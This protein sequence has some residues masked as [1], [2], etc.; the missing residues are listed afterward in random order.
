MSKKVL[1]VL[2]L[3][4]L[5][6]VALLGCIRMPSNG[7]PALP[8]LS[9]ELP[10]PPSEELPSAPSEELTAPPSEEAPSYV[11][12][13]LPPPPVTPPEPTQLTMLSITEGDV[14]VMKSGTNTW[15]KARVSMNLD[16][17]DT[18]RAGD[19]SK[20]VITFFDGSVIELEAGAIVNV[21]K[22]KAALDTGATAIRLRQ[23]IGKTISR[24]KKFIDPASR[25]EVETPA[26]TMAVRG[27]IVHVIVDEEG[28]TTVI[29]EKGSGWV[30]AQGVR[31][32]V[33]EGWQ[34]T[35]ILGKPPGFVVPWGDSEDEVDGVYED[36]KGA[37]PTVPTPEADARWTSCASLD[38]PGTLD[39]NP[40]GTN[41]GKDVGWTECKIDEIDP[42]ILRVAM[43]NAYPGYWN[44]CQ[45]ELQNVGTVPIMIPQVII[46][47]D[48]FNLA[49]GYGQDDGELWIDIDDRIGEIK[50]NPGE[51][52]TLSLQ[53]HVEQ[54][55]AQS[56]TYTVSVQVLVVQ[57][58]G[59]G[60]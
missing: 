28:T 17:G 5:V 1:S 22:L 32:Y 34:C 24:V 23:E 38:H 9:D 8:P 47:P 25:Y 27:S 41:K 26:A 31:R 21:I 7:E 53:I 15:V 56:T 40:D 39:P 11:S 52:T 50:L 14:Y 55:A 37:M 3:A 20:A 33:P 6:V 4:C 43:H 59:F 57:H 42:R 12:K 51:S 58:N 10:S 35:T 54:S 36:A 46:I 48:N 30:M 60:G 44:E 2:V 45:V 19:D 13:E 18:V 29:F 49:S 16:T